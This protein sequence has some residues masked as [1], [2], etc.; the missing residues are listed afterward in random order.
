MKTSIMKKSLLD[1]AIKGKLTSRFRRENPQLSA[2]DEIKAYNAQIA[3]TRKIKQK[4]LAK[5]EKSLKE[6]GANKQAIKP[7]IQAMKK[8]IAKLKEIEILALNNETPFEIPSSWAWVKLGDI[9]E[10]NIGLTYNPNDIKQTGIPV[11]RSNNIQNGEIVYDDLIYIDKNFQIKENYLVHKNDIL[12]CARNGS[13]KL[14]GKVALIEKENMAFGAFMTLIRSK[15]SIF[16]KIYFES[17]IFRNQLEGFTT[18]TINQITQEKLKNFLIPLPPL[19]EQQAIAQ[20]LES[21]IRLA[22]EFEATQENLKRIEKRIEKS[23]LHCAILGKLSAKFRRENPQLSAYDEIADYNEQIANTR[24]EKQKQ[25]AKLEKSLKEKGADKQAIKPKIATLKKEIAKLKEIEILALNNEVAFEI[26][27]SWAWVKL[28]DICEISSGGTPARDKA[29]FWQ[30]GDIAWVK[31]ADIKSDFI[32]K[33]AEYIT[34]KG[35]ENS[36]A[37]IFPKGTLLYTIFATLGEVGIL[38]IDATTNQAI[39]GLSKRYEYDTKFLMYVLR[40]KKD[41]VN[42]LGRGLAQS[43]IN[44]TMLKDFL[45]PLPPLNEQKAIAKEL[46]AL[47]AIS[48]GLRVE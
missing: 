11:L 34:Q 2:Y 44:Q 13:S 10:S 30:N 31:I 9:A 41:Y 7:Q 1:Y 28:G 16:L 12:M 8:E 5:L 26:P 27:S 18:T 38:N 33:T 14:V 19:N 37:K 22:S 32:D 15:F 43:N 46:D 47:F 36:S 25:L 29:E 6:K 20:K 23:L 40:S 4:Q 42:N 39:A 21:L 3:N 48:K 35:L 45:I 24:K 17:A